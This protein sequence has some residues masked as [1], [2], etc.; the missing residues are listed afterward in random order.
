MEWREYIKQ[1]LLDCSDFDNLL[2]SLDEGIE[3]APVPPIIKASLIMLEKMIKNQ[4]KRN[5]FIFPEMEESFLIFV[6]FKVFYNILLGKIKGDYNPKRFKKGEILKLGNAVVQFNGIT[7]VSSTDCI[8]VVLAEGTISNAPMALC[9]AFQ[10]VETKRKLSKYGAFKKEKERIVTEL[11]AESEKNKYLTRIMQSKTHMDGSIGVVTSVARICKQV[12]ETEINSKRLSDVFLFASANYEGE[13]KNIA[14]GQLAGNPAMI[15]TSDLYSVGAVMEQPKSRIQSLIVDVSNSN[16]IQNQLDALDNLLKK[17]IPIVCLTD[18][19]N[20]YEIECF[21]KR[22]FNIWQWN[23]S[24]ITEDLCSPSPILLSEKKLESFK[25]LCVE[26]LFDDDYDEMSMA[27]NELSRSKNDVLKASVSMTKVFE[28]LSNLTFNAIRRITPFADTDSSGANQTL[29]ECVEILNAEK[30]FI[31]EENYKDFSNVIDVLEKVYRPNF[32]LPKIGLLRSRLAQI[33]EDKVVLVISNKNDKNLAEQFWNKWDNNSFRKVIVMYP[34]EYINTRK[35]VGRTVIVGWLKHSIMRKIFYS[36]VSAKYDVLLYKCERKWQGCEIYYQQKLNACLCNKEI[37]KKS[38]SGKNE[39]IDV[40]NLVVPTNVPQTKKNDDELEE[41]ESIV[42]DNRIKRY[43]KNG[44]SSS[45]LIDVIPVSFIG[46]YL[47]F[48]RLEHKIISVSRI[49]SGDD[50]DAGIDL[51]TPSELFEGDFIAVRETNRDLIKEIADKILVN[52]GKNSARAEARLWKDALR[53]EIALGNQEDLVKKLKKNGC[54]KGNITIQKWLDDDNMI[55]PKLRDDIEAIALA[56]EN[57]TLYEKI[58]QVCI[59]AS[60]IRAAHI[61][62]GRILSDELKK[63][64]AVKLRTNS[65][66]PFNIWDPFDIYIENV[67]N[68]KILKVIDIGSKIQVDSTD[69]NRLIRD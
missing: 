58:D 65:V 51:K 7:Q 33:T 64:I 44:S 47:S 2:I 16:G 45:Q 48:Y 63:K 35:I 34:D 6:I 41:I 10:K 37:V 12:G 30:K 50:N 40:A 1:M 69:V 9:P 36:G 32:T 39:I 18:N 5:L 25:N 15:F 17:D 55:A 57:E 62:A 68:I 14:P 13:I 43:A 27:M 42:R 56:T 67:G 53:I 4:G 20:S 29:H 49:I 19:A 46:N 24:N 38:L 11:A 3:K 59:A 54:N 28:I 61:K 23:S 66:D 60:D 8:S 26:Y 21:K 22:N 31:S 52:Q